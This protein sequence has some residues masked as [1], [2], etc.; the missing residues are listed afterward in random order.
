VAQTTQGGDSSQIDILFSQLGNGSH[1]FLRPLVFIGRHQTH[2]AFGKNLFAQLGYGAQNRNAAILFD[3]VAQYFF[4][5]GSGNM[6]EHNTP[7]THV[8][9]KAHT[10]GHDRSHGSGALGAVDT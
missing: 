1:S 9:I 8:R 4:M 3:A 10:T 7:N 6:I 5:T 2:V